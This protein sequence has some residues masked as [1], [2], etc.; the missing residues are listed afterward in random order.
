MAMTESTEPQESNDLLPCP[1]CGSYNLDTGENW[2]C[3]DG[4]VSCEDCNAVVT[5]YD[6]SAAIKKW[7]LRT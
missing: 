4:Y 2:G 5:A 1:F 6:K 7:N 3:G